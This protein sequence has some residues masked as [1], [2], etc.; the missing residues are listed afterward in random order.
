MPSAKFYEHN[1]LI[2]VWT[3]LVAC[4]LAALLSAQAH[5]QEV[6]FSSS[7]VEAGNQVY[8]D[9]CVICHGTTLAN[10]QFGTPLR[11]RV[12]QQKWSGKSLGELLEYT[13]QEMPPDNGMM[14]PLERYAEVLA[15]ILQGN[16]IDAGEVALEADIGTARSTPLPW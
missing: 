7:Q 12:F 10:G 15:F 4:W 2:L 13:Y 11:G 8:R 16:G 5:A 9:H 14:L 1:K 3:L 6:E